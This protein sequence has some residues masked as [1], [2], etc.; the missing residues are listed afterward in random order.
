MD[1]A[2]LM[3]M[4]RINE[5]L[6]N[7]TL[8]LESTQEY[9]DALEVLKKTEQDIIPKVES[10]EDRRDLE[11]LCRQVRLAMGTADRKKMEEAT[12]ALNDRLLN[13][14]YLL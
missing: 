2:Q 3:K 5:E 7:K 1:A 10:P 13:F 14:A 6:V 12:A 8:E 9:K 11:E 4:K